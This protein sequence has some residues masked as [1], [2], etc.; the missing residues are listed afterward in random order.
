[1]DNLIYIPELAVL[2]A[3]HLDPAS[4]AR[5][6]RVCRAWHAAF[7]PRLWHTFGCEQPFSHRFGICDP[8]QPGFK[9]T[10]F[11]L[12]IHGPPDP[13]NQSI[14][15]TV[16]IFSLANPDLYPA[17]PE[18]FQ[19]CPILGPTPSHT[20]SLWTPFFRGL[21]SDPADL[22]FI[23]AC[24]EK[25]SRH[26]RCL[27]VPSFQVFQEVEYR[28]SLL[29]ALA[30]WIE[31]GIC[32]D[33]IWGAHATLS[34]DGQR[35]LRRAIE[36]F[37]RRQ[38]FLEAISCSDPPF[39]KGKHTRFI[40]QATIDPSSYDQQ[41]QLLDTHPSSSSPPRPFPH[42]SP[43][44][45]RRHWKYVDVTLRES[46]YVDMLT[47]L[48]HVRYARFEI[49]SME[50]LTRPMAHPQTHMREL[51]LCTS[52][53]DD[54][55]LRAVL[56]SFPNLQ[57]LYV[58]NGG[59]DE[60]PLIDLILDRQQRRRYGESDPGGGGGVR[61]EGGTMLIYRG[62]LE[63]DAEVA[64][65]IAQLP[66]LIAFDYYNMKDECFAAL[67]QHCPRLRHVRA[68]WEG[69]PVFLGEDDYDFLP[70][71]A[72]SLLL[73]SCPDLETVDCPDTPLHIRHVL[74]GGRWICHNLRY[75]RCEMLGIPWMDWSYELYES[76][77]DCWSEMAPRLS[78]AADPM[79]ALSSEPSFLALSE[80]EQ[81]MLRTISLR[82][83]C[84]QGMEAQLSRVP[85]LRIDRRCEC[86]NDYMHEKGY[87]NYLRNKGKTATTNCSQLSNALA[88]A[89]VTVTNTNKSSSQ[90]VP[91]T[92]DVG[93]PDS[94]AAMDPLME[95]HEKQPLMDGSLII[96]GDFHL[97]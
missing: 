87:K 48:P 85:L 57:R 26:I 37:A 66:D 75:L 77:M 16:P 83:Q 84:R 89:A 68:D 20:N 95:Q 96:S 18:R 53:F 40:T 94:V 11:P 81:E 21:W 43:H 5:C 12:H 33:G 42:R 73:T 88:D 58:H 41:E 72:I 60:P 56:E 91:S 64:R 82:E 93:S 52:T 35:Q 10:T 27:V 4:L 63:Q 8:P 7:I 22:A 24:L 38:P 78:L 74:D 92:S 79:N 34:N 71:Q 2:L 50:V 28:C 67:A 90:S 59:E 36:Q 9:Y 49:Q 39:L 70:S 47:C 76:L 55:C 62:G 54:R 23:R 46:D 80:P 29:R 14:S 13:Q 3:S 17:R 97:T 31:P 44:G 19:F 51:W 30:I 32:C 65:M 61:A 6:V 1:M 86:W 25:Y 45:G 15:H 69:E